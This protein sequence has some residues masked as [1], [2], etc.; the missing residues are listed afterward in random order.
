MKKTFFIIAVMAVLFSAC[1]DKADNAYTISGILPA[2]VEAKWVY[3]Y[4]LNSQE[5]VVIDSAAIS[6]G[7]FTLKGL[8]PDSVVM[9]V[10]HPGSIYD[11]PA[12]A[13]NLVLEPG[14]LTVDTVSQF[15]SGAPINDGLCDWMTQIEDIMNLNPDPSGVKTFFREH[16]NEHSS[17]FVGSFMLAQLAMYLDFPFI[18]SLTAQVP[19]DVRNISLLKPFFEQIETVRSSQPGSSFTDVHLSTIDG[20]EASLSDYIGKGQYVLVDFWASWCGPCRQAMPELKSVVGKHK[21]LNVIGIALSDKLDDTKKAIVDLDI[22]WTVLT[23]QEGKSAH[24][25]GISAIPAMILFGP[26]GTIAARDFMVSGLEDLLNSK[27]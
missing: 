4:S 14:N 1:G 18:D 9:A 20:A 24:A 12:V 27:L 8:V 25:Y 15:A 10:L 17:D 21:N 11:Y 16:W 3:L 19:A 13:W 6:N 22:P 7:Q 23:D 26:D 2:N 5:P